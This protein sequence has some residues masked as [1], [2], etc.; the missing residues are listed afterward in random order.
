L[1]NALKARRNG[2]AGDKKSASLKLEQE[3]GAFRT[4][5]EHKRLKKVITHGPDGQVAGKKSQWGK[6]DLKKKRAL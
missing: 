2:K 1:S 3:P 4:G 5:S 6:S